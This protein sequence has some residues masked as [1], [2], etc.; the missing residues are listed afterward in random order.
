MKKLYI[1]K[2]GG[3]IIDDAARLKDFLVSF[4]RLQ[5]PKILIHGGG[6]IASE[7][8]R[9]LGI[10][11]V[12]VEGRR[13][14][15]KK[16]LDVVTMVYGGLI[17]KNIVALLQSFKCNALGLTGA[18]MNILPA[19]KREVIDMDYGYVGDIEQ[20]KIPVP[21]LKFL[22]ANNITPV[23]APLT[24]DRNGNLLN[25][26]ADSIAN[27]LA[28]SL[29]KDFEVELL[30]CF[31]KKGVHRDAG[32]TIFEQINLSEYQLL[33]AEKVITDGMIPKLD[34]AFDALKKGVH[35]VR[36]IHA[37][38]IDEVVKNKSPKGTRLYV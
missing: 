27:A 17:N 6:K 38:A 13:I 32:D 26:N 3:N 22:L 23:V 1:L 5:D 14:T 2:I 15:D 34:N 30:F 9:Q 16:T 4:S 7:I 10:E 11:P 25:T 24:H 35:S 21:T 28:I 19:H 18:D 8:S 20:E 33:K 37:Q 29:C 12:I 31:E 36:I